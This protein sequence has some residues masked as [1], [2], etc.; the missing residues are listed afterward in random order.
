MVRASSM[1]KAPSLRCFFPSCEPPRPTSSSSP[2][3]DQCTER[4]VL[5]ITALRSRRRPPMDQMRMVLSSPVVANRSG[6]ADRDRD[7]DKALLPPAQDKGQV[8]SGQTSGVHAEAPELAGVVR[9]VHQG[10]AARLGR[11]LV[12]LPCTGQVGTAQRNT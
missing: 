11:D 7:R 3:G 2:S 4:A 8:R 9:L 6:S 1:R 10:D 5:S 12:H